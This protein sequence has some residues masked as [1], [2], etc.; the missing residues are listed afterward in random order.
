MD[1]IN[2]IE[3]VDDEITDK[4]GLTCRPDDTTWNEV[5]QEIAAA[6]ASRP[7]VVDAITPEALDILTAH[8]RHTARRAAEMVRTWEPWKVFRDRVTGAELT[9]YTMRGTFA[10]EEEDTRE[11]IAHDHG[12]SPDR[13]DV[14]IELRG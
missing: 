6:L 9:A 7:E 4:R 5:V 1:I 8:N 3:Q 13:I 11:L 12:I 2:L 14:G 10:G